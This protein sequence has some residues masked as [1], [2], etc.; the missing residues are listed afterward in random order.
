[1]DSKF[2]S[3]IRI[4]DACHGLSDDEVQSVAAQGQIVH[5]KAGEII[6]AAGQNL[7]SMYLVLRGRLKMMLKTPGGRRQTIRYV[8]V[9]DQFG[10]LILFSEENSPVDVEVDETAILMKFDREVV[11]QLAEKHPLMRRNLMRKLGG[12]V[13]DS[14][15]K[16]RKRSPSKIVAFIHT[17]C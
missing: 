6:H 16:Q 4:H 10:A 17:S 3:L 8:A 7:E 1:M 13:R 9:G 15:M 14:L 12:A 5:A 2:L 11:T